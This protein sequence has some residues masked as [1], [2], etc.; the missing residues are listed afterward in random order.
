MLVTNFLNILFKR[1]HTSCK[2]QVNQ[3]AIPLCKDHYARILTLS[4]E[5]GN[6]S[7]L[8]PT[9]SSVIHIG[10]GGTMPARK[11]SLL[12]KLLWIHISPLPQ[13]LTWPPLSPP[14]IMLGPHLPPTPAIM[15]ET[16]YICVPS[17]R[18]EWAIKGK[19]IADTV[20]YTWKFILSIVKQLHKKKYKLWDYCHANI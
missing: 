20:V 13:P 7:G 8:R 1:K 14:P 18:L 15:L 17:A 19:E 5:W 2:R 12:L 10:C 16:M 6:L 11:K 3:S 4:L 9:F